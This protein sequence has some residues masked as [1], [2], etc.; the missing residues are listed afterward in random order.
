MGVRGISTKRSIMAE[1]DNLEHWLKSIEKSKPDT[2]DYSFPSDRLRNEYITTIESRT[3]LEVSN[4]VRKFLIPSGSLG[5]DKSTLTWL[6]HLVKE[7]PRPRVTEFQKRL[8]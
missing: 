5:A 2:I 4:L 8:V 3:N 7:K 1:D 6:V